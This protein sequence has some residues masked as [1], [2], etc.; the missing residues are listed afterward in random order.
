MY[1]V[2]SLKLFIHRHELML[3]ICR[4][5]SRKITSYKLSLA[6]T[7]KVTSDEKQ[8]VNNDPINF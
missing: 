7:I 8:K 2:Y 1:S 4:F 3:Y 5:G 6:F